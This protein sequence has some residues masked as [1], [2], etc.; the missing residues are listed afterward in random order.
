MRVDQ[1]AAVVALFATATQWAVGCPLIQVE[2]LGRSIGSEGIH[3]ESLH[4]EPGFQ[5]VP[6]DVESLCPQLG[7][8]GEVELEQRFV[9]E[10]LA[11][12]VAIRLGQ[13]PKLEQW[14]RDNLLSP[15]DRK[16][17]PPAEQWDP[18]HHFRV[19]HGRAV[20]RYWRQPVGRDGVLREQ[21]EV[22]SP[23]LLQRRAE[24]LLRQEEQ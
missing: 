14:A 1:K 13:V 19:G 23:S 18:N 2:Q 16:V 15:V 5:V 17:H 21:L 6:S 11:A 20:I 10:R 8:L 12:I 7:T 22:R 3:Q 24:R 4:F 9:D